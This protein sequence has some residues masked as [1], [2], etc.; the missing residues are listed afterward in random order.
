MPTLDALGITYV[1]TLTEYAEY[2]FVTFI[3][4]VPA[5]AATSELSHF[6]H[7]GLVLYFD[8]I[9][10]ENGQFDWVTNGGYLPASRVSGP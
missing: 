3:T 4:G 1:P 7:P 10:S 8:F 6:L 2:G 9:P 5:S